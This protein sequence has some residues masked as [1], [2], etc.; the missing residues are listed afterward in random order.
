MTPFDYTI[1]QLMRVFY[2][3]LIFKSKEFFLFFSYF[4][5]RFYLISIKYILKEDVWGVQDYIGI[6]KA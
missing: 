2:M 3:F 5:L 4:I 6:N 1:G